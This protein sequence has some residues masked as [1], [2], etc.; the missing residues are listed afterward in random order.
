MGEIHKKL[1]FFIFFY[2]NPLDKN[3]SADFKGSALP[4]RTAKHDPCVL[5]VLALYTT[6]NVCT[7][8]EKKLG[9]N[10]FREMLQIITLFV[11]CLLQEKIIACALWNCDFYY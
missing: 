10:I 6:I 2:L 7:I 11:F 3:S 9:R 8:G 5:V 1:Y 4:S